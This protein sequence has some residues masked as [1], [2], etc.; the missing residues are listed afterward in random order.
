MTKDKDTEVIILERLETLQKSIDIID[1]DLKND[2]EDIQEYRVRIGNLEQEVN[3]LRKNLK[4]LEDKI[5]NR[6]AETIEPLR[7]GIEDK[8]IVEYK[9][10]P[11]WKFWFKR[12]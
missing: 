3:E 11:F 9:G 7:E 12:G 5:Q 2:R 1:K 8:Q 4:N 6:I 10:R